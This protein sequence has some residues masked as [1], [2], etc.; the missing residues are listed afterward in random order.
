M[1]W[2]SKAGL[3]FGH[4]EK[5]QGKINQNSKKK[6]KTQENISKFRHFL[7]EFLVSNVSFIVY[8]E[9]LHTYVKSQRFSKRKQNSESKQNPHN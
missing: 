4:R 8:L 5:T 6:L 3:I 9:E 2:V 1:N 7:G